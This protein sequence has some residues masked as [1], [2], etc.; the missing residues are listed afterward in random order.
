MRIS[1][2]SSD[3]CSSDLPALERWRWLGR[4][5]GGKRHRPKLPRKGGGNPAPAL[6]GEKR[7]SATPV[8]DARP[9]KGK[10]G[11]GSLR[12]PRP[13]RTPRRTPSPHSPFA[14]LAALLEEG[15]KEIGRAHV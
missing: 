15:R 1:D 11:K 14:G 10:P 12:P 5:S 9:K 7:R 13:D 8:K 2:W 6:N 4:R 3:V